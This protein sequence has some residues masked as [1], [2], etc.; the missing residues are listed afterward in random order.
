MIRYDTT[1]EN[2]HLVLW[3]PLEDDIGEDLRRVLVY[4]GLTYDVKSRADV[5]DLYGDRAFSD[6]TET[7]LRMGVAI[8]RQNLTDAFDAGPF[9]GFVWLFD[10]AYV[11]QYLT[12]Q[13]SG[14]AVSIER[15]PN[16]PLGRVE[17]AVRDHLTES[18]PSA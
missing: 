14:V 18:Y 16:P 11:S 1:S 10:D 12:D 2:L 17:R 6:I 13:F 9:S 8:D 3:D 15:T 4:D 7:F 5:D